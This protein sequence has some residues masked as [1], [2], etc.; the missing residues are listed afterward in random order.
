MIINVWELRRAKAADILDEHCNV[1]MVIRSARINEDQ[2]E[3]NCVVTES[4]ASS[5]R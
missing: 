5:E 4:K 1:A 3:R 2:G